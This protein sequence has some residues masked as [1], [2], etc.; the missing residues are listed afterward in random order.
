MDILLPLSPIKYSK[1]QAII[2]LLHK[3]L[4]TKNEQIAVLSKHLA[5]SQKLL[6]QE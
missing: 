4:E 3:E 2:E 1:N 5:E 6:N